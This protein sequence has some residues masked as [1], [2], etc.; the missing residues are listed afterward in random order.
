MTWLL[1]ALCGALVVAGTLLTITGSLPAP[2][3]PARPV[4]RGRPGRWDRV[5]PTTRRLLVAGLGVGV[6]VSMFTG[7]ILAVPLGP[8]VLAG[9][10]ALLKQPAGKEQL[11]GVEA[12][13]EWVRA[14]AG[15]LTAGSGLES[16]IATSVRSAPERVRPA[17]TRL[18]ARLRVGWSTEEAVRAWGEEIADATGDLVAANLILASRRRGVAV[19]QVLE[20]LAQSLADEVIS[21]REVEADRA[22]T[23]QTVRIVTLVTFGLLAYLPFTGNYVQPYTTALGQLILGV[24]LAAFA[25]VLAWMRIMAVPPPA[26]RILLDSGGFAKEGSR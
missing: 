2:V 15:I 14:L 24:L 21:R 7:W 8:V 9:V 6:L 20:A 4:S 17:V 11:L 16:A 1:P 3:R 19:A 12:M 13:E 22:K 25:G 5:S 23:T 10:P 26:P 18:A